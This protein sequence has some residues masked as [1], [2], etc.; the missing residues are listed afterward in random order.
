MTTVTIKQGQLEGTETG[1]V[2]AFFGIPYAAPPYGPHRLVAPAPAAG[3]DGVRP[4]AAYGPT[5]LKNGYPAVIAALLPEPAIPGEDCLNLNV[6][7]P[8]P[9]RAG[10]PVLVWIHG[11][12][13]TYGSGA[14]PDYD[15]SAF[16]RDGVVCVTINY[17]LGVDGFAWLDGAPPNRGLLD[18][19]AALTWVRDNITAFGGDPDRVTIAG[20]SAGAMSVATLMAMPA[21]AGLFARAVP[22]SGAGHHAISA[23][24]ARRI[25][26]YLADALGVAPTAAAV[27]AVPLDR[28]LDA[29]ADLVAGPQRAPDP[30]RWG[31][32]A[33]NVMVFEPVVDGDVLPALPIDAIRAGAG[34]GVDV[35]VGTNTD[36]QRLFVVP[37]GLLDLIDDNLLGLATAGWDL[38]AA[39]IDTYRRGRPDE[40]PGE[41]VCAIGTD[42]FFRIPAIRL[43]EARAA[44]PGSTHMY[45]FAWPSPRFDGRL[46]ACHALEIPFVFDSLGRSDIGLADAADAPTQL[47]AEM[48]RAWVRFVTDGDP[49]WSAYDPSRRA[50]MRFDVTSGV[51]DDPRPDERQVWDGL[52]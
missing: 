4:A 40:S 10:L 9:G 29:Q 52:R 27:G 16:A 2:H 6:W 32:V 50:T 17:R 39:G 47:V 19:V 30:E 15:G 38:P 5:A 28:L 7:T 14:V 35:L 21:A 41:L 13:F 31:E 42:W 34:A 44:A 51:V 18:Q 46:G 24:T 22:Q 1:G 48:H 37:V 33:R 43:A 12:A 8:D 3:W 26:G 20:E 23:A 25:G 45:E 36:E 49:G 11:G